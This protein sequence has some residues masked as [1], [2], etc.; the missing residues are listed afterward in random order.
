M[1]SQGRGA[2]EDSLP[3]SR[4]QGR[5]VCGAGGVGGPGLLWLSGMSG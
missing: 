2:G 4:T 3:G 5:N 1:G